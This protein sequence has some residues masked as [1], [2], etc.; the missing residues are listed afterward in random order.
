MTRKG[1]LAHP[2]S[3]LMALAGFAFFAYAFNVGGVQGWLDGIL[4]GLDTQAKSHNGE[5]SAMFVKA[6]PYIAVVLGSLAGIY[7][8]MLVATLTKS[9]TT[10][11]K[12]KPKPAKKPVAVA[13]AEAS[14]TPAVKPATAAAEFIRPA[15]LAVLEKDMKP[16]VAVGK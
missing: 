4:H 1:S 15:R 10:G 8:L 12:K 3:I 2:G 5:V 13:V 9:L 11:K 16:K 14:A 7:M 6:L